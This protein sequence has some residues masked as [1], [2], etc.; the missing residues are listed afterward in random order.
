VSEPPQ[1]QDHVVVNV[2]VGV[3]PRHGS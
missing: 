1:G 3:E 2:L